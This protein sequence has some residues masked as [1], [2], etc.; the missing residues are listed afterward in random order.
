MSEGKDRRI[1]LRVSEELYNEI[2]AT[3][4][5]FNTKTKVQVNKTSVIT[6]AITEGLKVLQKRISDGQK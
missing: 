3:V 2:E 4:K 5:L 6:S 1:G